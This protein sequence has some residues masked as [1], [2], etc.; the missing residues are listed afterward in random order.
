[1]Q[2]EAAQGVAR[3]QIADAERRRPVEA[4]PTD[5]GIVVGAVTKRVVPPWP[6]GLAA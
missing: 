2:R 6:K 4:I 1:M 5:S 3:D